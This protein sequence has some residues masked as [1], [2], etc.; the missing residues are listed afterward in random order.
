MER[1]VRNDRIRRLAR[2]AARVTGKSEGTVIQ[3][4]L[5]RLLREHGVDPASVERPGT[6]TPGHPADQVG[7]EG[8]AM[9]EAEGLYDERW[10][11]P[12]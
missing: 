6:P 8:Q 10:G 5:E 4:A 11:Y 3:E 2:E 12:R 9:R 1:Q 7:P